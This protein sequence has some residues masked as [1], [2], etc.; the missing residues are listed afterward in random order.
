MVNF[1]RDNF[2]RLNTEEKEN[3]VNSLVEKNIKLNK[4]EIDYL[5]SRNRD[6]YVKNL[7]K[8]SDWMDDYEFNVLNNEEQKN[9]I[10]RKRFLDK[11]LLKNIDLEVFKSYID[12]VISSK[13]YFT[14]EEFKKIP[15]NELKS[16]YSKQKSNILNDAKLYPEELFFLNSEEQINYLKN[17]KKIGFIPNQEDFKYIKP[18]AL[19]FYQTQKTVNEI[20]KIIKKVL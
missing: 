10:N 1:D 13:L 5:T 8:T 4:K 12:K 19:R 3:F 7:I 11:S 6:K 20:K 9:Y 2:D 16:Y 14:K 18:K 17:L 15:T